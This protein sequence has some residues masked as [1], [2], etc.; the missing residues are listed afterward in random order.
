M[1][2]KRNAAVGDRVG[3]LVWRPSPEFG[4]FPCR[5]NGHGQ[6]TGMATARAAAIPVEYEVLLDGHD[7]DLVSL[8]PGVGQDPVDHGLL[9]GPVGEPHPP[10]RSGG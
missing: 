6:R 4:A 7:G 1:V 10:R 8:A 5:V 2:V 3:V 9:V